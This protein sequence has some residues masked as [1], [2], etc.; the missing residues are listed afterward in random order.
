M[1]GSG[2]SDLS[3][4]THVA[5]LDANK[6]ALVLNDLGELAAIIGFLVHG[7]MEEDDSTNARV[8]P[9]ISG[10]EQLPVEATVFFGVLGADGLQA[11]GNAA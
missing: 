3:L 11:L 7:L 5:Y 4:A 1:V 9:V 2:I 10:E 8:D 6:A